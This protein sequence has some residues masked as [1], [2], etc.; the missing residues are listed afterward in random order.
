MISVVVPIYNTERY[1]RR[2]L[3]S[4]LSQTLKDW[5]AILVDDGSTDN[6]GN[7]AEEYAERD[8]RFKVIHKANG[9][10]S[11]ARN[12]G[13]QHTS[14]E[15]LL[16]LD[17]DDFMHSQLMEL[18]L[19]AMFRDGSDLVAFTYDHLYRTKN[20]IRHFLHLGDST[21][22]FKFYKKPPYIV[23]DNIFAYATEYS[24]PR[25]IDRRWAVKHCQ[26]WRCMYKT[27]AVRDIKFIKG[28]NYED[29][30]WWSEVLLRIKRC[31]ILNLPLYFYY[32]NPQ[33]YLLS[34]DQ[35]HKAESL[36]QGIE[37]SKR[38]YAAAPEA[39]R[40][41][42]ERNFLAPFEQKLKRKQ[43]LKQQK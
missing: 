4:I 24:R 31:T 29:F 41:T 32:P 14:G 19:E 5:E 35:T 6:S 2:A 20:L 23:T 17:S 37:A 36:R 1:L 39:K 11:D 9:G 21:P 28:I 43:G 34:A 16:F 40:Q 27:Y 8:H 12:T 7:I 13:L 26:V 33:S 22:H 3:D 10:L 25:N 30:P 42:W 38:I 18:C 15:Y